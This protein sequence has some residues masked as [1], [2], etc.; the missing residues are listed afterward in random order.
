MITLSE[1]RRIPCFL[2]H[3]YNTFSHEG[4]KRKDELIHEIIPTLLY[5]E[6]LEAK[7]G[8]LNP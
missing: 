1:K 6:Y 7:D 2:Y 8:G 4:N 3:I 5:V